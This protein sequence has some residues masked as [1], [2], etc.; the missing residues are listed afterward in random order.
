MEMKIPGKHACI[1]G[2]R[3]PQVL[4][5]IG[6]GL[7]RV[8]RL[9]KALAW[10]GH[11]FLRIELHS[12]RFLRLTMPNEGP[13]ESLATYSA[14]DTVT[15]DDVCLAS[16]L[17][18]PDRMLRALIPSVWWSMG[19]DVSPQLVDLLVADFVRELGKY[20]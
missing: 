15:F 14:D 6:K 2:I 8:G 19:R 4:N 10:Q 18:N 7:E 12:V 20:D 1:G 5:A 11:T 17:K 9:F 16:E 3:G 13:Y